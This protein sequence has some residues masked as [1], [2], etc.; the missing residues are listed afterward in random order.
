MIHKES[1][2]LK[3]LCPSSQN[4]YPLLPISNHRQYPAVLHYRP[5]YQPANQPITRSVPSDPGANVIDH[6]I[7]SGLA[8]FA[9]F[10]GRGKSFAL[11]LRHFQVGGSELEKALTRGAVVVVARSRVWKPSHEAEEMYVVI[12][13]E[14]KRDGPVNG[15]DQRPLAR[16]Q[17]IHGNFLSRVTRFMDI[18]GR[19]DLPEGYHFCIPQVTFR[20]IF[21]F[22]NPNNTRIKLA[23]SKGW[24]KMFVALFQVIYA[25]ITLY[26]TR[27]DQLALFGYAAFGLSV[28]PYAFMSMAYLICTGFVGEYSHLYLLQTA[29]MAEAMAR[30]PGC[31]SGAI[32]DFE[33]RE[34]GAKDE[35]VASSVDDAAADENA[36]GAASSGGQNGPPDIFTHAKI[37]LRRETPSH[38]QPIDILKIQVDGRKPMEFTYLPPEDKFQSPEIT[39]KISCIAD[40]HRLP[41][42]ASSVVSD[43]AKLM[44]AKLMRFLQYVII[45]LALVSPYLLIY[46]L[47]RFEARSSTVTQRAWM[48]AWIGSGQLAFLI[49]FMVAM[50]NPGLCPTAISNPW[51]MLILPIIGVILVVI[52]LHGFII[53]GKMLMQFGTCSA[54]P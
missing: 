6:V 42:A 40:Q 51:G 46:L 53:V 26:R 45:P 44:N 12:P 49:H 21:P 20:H 1:P 35:Q 10:A 54:V 14:L 5:T 19:I 47:T 24:L 28:F 23:R 4:D 15:T 39:F 3:S 36:G 17:I 11:I 7:W 9:P 18:H 33:R 32:G 41:D 52:G 13:D 48:M 8:L 37:S 25:V 16:I 43:R 34:P 29:I 2:P 27:G 31:I 30:K 50:A 22:R 38:G